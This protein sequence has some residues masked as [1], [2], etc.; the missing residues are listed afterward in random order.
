MRGLSMSKVRDDLGAWLVHELGM[1][2]EV[3]FPGIS[4]VRRWRWDW[5]DE[6]RRVAVEYEG[7]GVGHQSVGGLYRDAEKHSNA[8]VCGW[9][10][11]RCTAR[12]VAA[13]ECQRWVSAV[14][15]TSEHPER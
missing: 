10:V 8:T 13:G 7:R 3:R 9:R 4:G 6:G 12:S 1:V 11:I 5:A 14:M 2:P 15:A